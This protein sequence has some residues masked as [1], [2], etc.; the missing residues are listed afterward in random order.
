MA[1]TKRFMDGGFVPPNTYPFASQPV[2]DN[3]VNIGEKQEPLGKVMNTQEP[4][5]FYKRGGKVMK[6]ADGGIY[7][8]KMGQPP[9]D[10]EVAKPSKKKPDPDAEIFTAEKLKGKKKEA[11]RDLMPEDFKKAKKFAKGGSVRG[12][13]CEVKGKTKGRMV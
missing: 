4:D 8:A 5:T 11:P 10:D 2:N 9:M 12:G 1:K 3:S 7:T 13:G 6:Y